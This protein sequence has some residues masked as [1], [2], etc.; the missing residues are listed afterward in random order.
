MVSWK[1]PRGADAVLIVWL[2]ACSSPSDPESQGAG[3]GGMSGSGGAPSGGDAATAGSGATSAGAGGS[4]GSTATGGAAGGSA[5]TVGS[6]T[7][8]AEY[9]P[10]SWVNVTANL[11][12]MTTPCGNTYRI[13]SHPTEDKVIVG[14]VRVGLYAST[15]GGTSW[16]LEGGATSPNHD[17]NNLRFDPEHA[18][19]YWAAG[20]HANPGVFKT[21]DDGSSFAA[22]GSV[23]NID[24]VSVDFTDPDRKTLLAGAHEQHVLYKSTDGGASFADITS[25]FPAGSAFTNGPLVVDANI[26][27]MG[28]AFY[29]ADA[30]EGVFRSSDGGTSW[31]QV[32]T[33]A[34]IGNGLK[35]SWGTLFYG[36]A[37]GGKVLKGSADGAT[38]TAVPVPGASGIVIELPGNRIA[39]LVKN[40]NVSSIGMSVDDGATWTTAADNVPALSWQYSGSYLTYDAVRG[41]FFVSF[42]D[43]GT[44]VHG[45]SLW[46]Y[47]TEL[48]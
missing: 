45:D 41:A 11:A 20:M 1:R 27:L 32:S 16:V 38:W 24:D 13:W 33:S 48:Q 18:E 34:V 14:L 9:M 31:T 15:D 42:W 44:T 30:S 40:G 28:T 3:A 10:G 47:D 19:V 35:T 8:G 37:A 22:L 43:C 23:S 36:A 4:A 26:L 6:G 29:S 39:T 25:V 2:V 7:G 12:D 5:G 46:R 17:H 21:T